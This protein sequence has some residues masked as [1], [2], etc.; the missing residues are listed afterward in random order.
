MA[1]STYDE[2]KTTISSWIARGT[3]LDGNIDDFIDLAEAHMN[4]HLRIF[5]LETTATTATVD[6][7][8]TYA[9]P[10]D[11]RKA[12]QLKLGSDPAPLE[13]LSEK[14]MTD[15]RGS[16]L[17]GRPKQ[18]ALEPGDK[19]KLAP[20][21]NA[22]FSAILSYFAGVTALSSSNTSNVILVKSP[23]LYL[24]GSLVEAAEFI[25]DEPRVVKYTRKRD[26]IIFDMNKENLSDTYAYGQART[27]TGNP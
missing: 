11:F 27:D 4:R 21:P 12:V 23:D 19:F 10:T 22:V 2:L 5:K 18:W 26:Q 25:D 17:T 7:T 20:T 16:S 13:F 24:Y 15:T 8:A 6:G 3:D 9:L 14:H 1:F